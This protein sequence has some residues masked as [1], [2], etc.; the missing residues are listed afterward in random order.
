VGTDVRSSGLERAAGAKNSAPAFDLLESK[1]RPPHGFGGTVPRAQLI[2]LAESARE[3]PIVV[4]SAG[5]GWGK[6][7]LLAQWASQ[8]ERPFAWLSI[9]EGDNDPIVLLTYIAVALDRVSPLASSVFDALA[10]PGVSI[11]ATVVPRLGAALA[12]MDQQL[13]LVLDDLHL[14]SNPAGWDAVEALARHVPEGS[15]LTLSAR[16][17]P[18]LALGALR[19]H[20]LT[21][22]IGQDDLR[23]TETEAH[24]LLRAA[25]VELSDD[26]AAE[27]TRQ[28]E[29]WSAGLYLAALSLRAH[30]AKG[31]RATTFS[32]SDRLVSAYLE[33][34]VLGHVSADE[35]RFLTRTAVLER[36]S[37]QLCDAVLEDRGSSAMLESLARSNRFV[38]AL[39]AQGDWYRCH[40]LFQELLRA[41]LLRAE[42]D[43]VPELLHRAADWCEANALPETA[44]GY[45]QAAGEVDRVA[46]LVERCAMPAYQGGRIATAERWLAWL[47]EHGALERN[48]AVAVLAG[49]VAAIWGRPAEAER[50]AAAAERAS[51]EG[52]PSDGSESIAAW[53][54]LLRALR[55]GR[56]AARMRADAELATRT[57][58]RGSPFRPT[59]VLLLAIA[60]WLAGEVDKADDLMADV[61]DEGLDIGG[62]EPL[63]VALGER[64]AIAI[65][66]G[67]WVQAEELAGGAL[68][69][70]RESRLSE[71][72]T[73]VL[74]YAVA[75]RIAFHREDA[76]RA[77]A[78]LAR[79]QTLRTRLTHAL[80]YLSVQARLELG[81]A[82]LTIADVG[83]ART[84]LREIEAVLRRQPDLGALPAQVD[85][86]R[87]SLKT[88][89]ADAPG[90]S[91]L[92]AA[93][94]SLLPYLATH[95]SFPEIAERRCLS[96]HTVKSHA[97]AIYRK[98]NVTS[99]SDA[100]QRASQVGLL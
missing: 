52:T 19:A 17:G 81:R 48:A 89:R 18:A 10:S 45:A 41:Q 68:R 16:A 94:L 44:I 34:E 2:G 8:S 95:L 73:S 64:A 98:L 92:T 71:H 67:A 87:S 1:L 75:A 60:E 22:E 84:V 27:L 83:G 42:P 86:L 33:A 9:D 11:D 49:L 36:M 40:R 69:V 78:L 66:R 21:L 51:Y 4:V 25:G 7:T 29:G 76:T 32:G 46:R 79:A 5:P 61:V 58:A 50:L 47:E 15:Q 43:L 6:T 38:V 3:T 96:R 14:L 30:G 77:E 93:E 85:E 91:T 35:L 88:M 90:T 82:Y 31:D 20:G 37:G 59:A 80:P 55:C 100:V 24:Q 70:M 57:L 12:A 97:M 65:G 72:P 28:T 26:Q 74:V 13:V 63:A 99:R 54:A 53:L 62:P 39:D 23:M 56:G